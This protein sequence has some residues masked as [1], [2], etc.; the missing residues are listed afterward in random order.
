MANKINIKTLF[1]DEKEA[2]AKMLNDG[3]SKENALEVISY[4]RKKLIPSNTT[5]KADLD[6][7]R[8]FADD[9]LTSKEAVK[10][11]FEQKRQKDYAD[12][13]W[14]KKV[15]KSI[16]D[17]GVWGVSKATQMVWN[18]YDWW[19]SIFTWQKSDIWEQMDNIKNTTTRITWNSTASKVWDFTM[20]AWSFLGWAGALKKIW[21]GIWKVPLVS[22]AASNLWKVPWVSTFWN[23][24]TKAKDIIPKGSSLGATFWRNAIYWWVFSWASEIFENGSD[25]KMRDIVESAALWAGV[26]GVLW[27]WIE[28]WILWYWK[29]LVKWDFKKVW[30]D[31]LDDFS[32]KNPL[33]NQNI[34]SGLSNKINRF[35]KSDIEKFTK[36]TWE[37]PG[38]WAINRWMTKT[39]DDAVEEAV[40]FYQQSMKEADRWFESIVW[41]FKDDWDDFMWTMLA[42]L[43][44]RYEKTAAKKEKLAN[45]KDLFQKYEKEGLTM[46]EINKVKREYAKNFKYTWLDNASPQALKSANL[47]NGVRE[48]QLKLANNNGFKNIAD[49]NKN[50]QGWKAYAD[51]LGSQVTWK[52]G[53]N[54]ISLTDWLTLSGWNPAN[55]WMFLWKQ[56][57][58]IWKVQSWVMKMLW[59]QTKSPIVEA[60]VGGNE[61][62]GDYVS[63]NL[64]GFREKIKLPK[65]LELEIS[66]YPNYK[67]TSKLK[68]SKIKTLEPIEKIPKSQEKFLKNLDDVY[69]WRIKEWKIADLP[70]ELWDDDYFNDLLVRKDI[71]KE[72]EKSHWKIWKENM[73]ITANKPNH[74]IRDVDWFEGNINLIKEIDWWK[75]YFI[76]GARKFKEWRYIVHHTQIINSTETSLKTLLSRWIII[77]WWKIWQN[78]K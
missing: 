36:M 32:I 35:K 10:K 30:K 37:T 9:G 27:V 46:P 19:Q 31:L 44:E 75:N 16:F 28:K 33:K 17:A 8:G 54:A 1:S 70:K 22:K 62:I 26:W 7:L 4:N 78:K 76:I 50:T 55:I 58:K 48:W 63:K 61:S 24:A 29:D 59:K 52:Q 53:N 34:A 49:I 47:Q 21:T 25:A 68:W 2:Y 43:A 14:Y 18:T 38:E 11:F 69:N 57:W 41:K 42:D 45:I 15:W 20:E 73:I 13:P 5:S 51:M 40:K 3:F 56:I 71:L 77:F 72:I 74:I 6:V 65:K 23:I 67:I 12:L 60:R 66:K 64:N 39:W